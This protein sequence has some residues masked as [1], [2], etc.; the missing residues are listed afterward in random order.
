MC[1]VRTHAATARV[2]ASCCEIICQR[3]C[4][5]RTVWL[6]ILAGILSIVIISEAASVTTS[7]EG[8]LE[9]LEPC[10]TSS[11]FTG[12]DNRSVSRNL[13]LF[14]CGFIAVVAFC[15]K[16]EPKIFTPDDGG[17]C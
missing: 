2:G 3:L 10:K 9:M 17:C 1:R 13:P 8:W 12:D 15:S 14:L 6:A 4:H 7:C 5:D 11:Y 16:I